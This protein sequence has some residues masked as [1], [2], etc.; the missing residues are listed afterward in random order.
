MRPGPVPQPL[1]TAASLQTAI[2]LEAPSEGRLVDHR[3][4]C[5]ARPASAAGHFPALLPGGDAAQQGSSRQERRQR[6][7]PPSHR[8]P[9]RDRARVSETRSGRANRRFL[10]GHRPVPVHSL[11]PGDPCS[12]ATAVS[13]AV[14]GLTAALL[15]RARAWQVSRG[16]PGIRAAGRPPAERG[17]P[18]GWG[19]TATRLPSGSWTL[20]AG[21]R[22][23]R[24]RDRERLPSSPLGLQRREQRLEQSARQT[25]SLQ[26]PVRPLLRRHVLGPRARAPGVQV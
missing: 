11:G 17:G 4:A 6:P 26:E 12:D 20:A 19:V 9:E 24:A 13:G 1:G 18:A 21:V 23:P 8:D 22:P 15:R 14:L 16:Q 10:T 5:P 2:H 7:H 3:D 25:P